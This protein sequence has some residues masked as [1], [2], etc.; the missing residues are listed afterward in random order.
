MGGKLAL[1]Q[2][3]VYSHLKN[4]LKAG[5]FPFSKRN[6]KCFVR[7][8]FEFFLGVSKASVQSL[9]FWDKVREKLTLLKVEMPQLQGFSLC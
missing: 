9:G 2:K 7:W 8:M 1:P 6:L 5:K 4:N 3:E